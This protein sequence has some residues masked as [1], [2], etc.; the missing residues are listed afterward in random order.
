MESP[1]GCKHGELG[2]RGL[3]VRLPTS[4]RNSVCVEK[5]KDGCPINEFKIHTRIKQQ[6]KL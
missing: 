3:G 6:T 2:P 1:Q 5:P 4:R